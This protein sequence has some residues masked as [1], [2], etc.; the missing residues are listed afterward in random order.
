M[1]PF[2]IFKLGFAFFGVIVLGVHARHTNARIYALEHATV[3]VPDVMTRITHSDNNGW[4]VTNSIAYV[5]LVIPLTINS[6]YN[7]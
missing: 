7:K 6:N 2:Q 5:T 3:T 1:K 4:V